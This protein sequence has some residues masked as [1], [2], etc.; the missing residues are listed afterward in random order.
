MATPR[1][2]IVYFRQSQTFAAKSKKLSPCKTFAETGRTECSI[3]QNII[4]TMQNQQEKL[5]GYGSPEQ[6]YAEIMQTA[7]VSELRLPRGKR[8]IT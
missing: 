8:R 7:S 2:K 4:W 1:D 3:E 6:F 5:R